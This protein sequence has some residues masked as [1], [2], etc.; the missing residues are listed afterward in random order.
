VLPAVLGHAQVDADE[1]R[2]GCRGSAEV[3]ATGGGNRGARVE[4]RRQAVTIGT[5]WRLSFASWVVAAATMVSREQAIRP[6][7]MARPPSLESRGTGG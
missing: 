6:N 5:N 3:V 7:G 4:S 2:G 1:G